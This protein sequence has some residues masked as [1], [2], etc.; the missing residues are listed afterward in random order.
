[1]FYVLNFCTHEFRSCDTVDK[2][3]N[4]FSAL[5]EAGYK[6]GDIEIVNGF[7]DDSR[8]SVDEFLELKDSL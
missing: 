4:M 1:M 6:S 8:F 7:I 5:Q 3:V 2:V